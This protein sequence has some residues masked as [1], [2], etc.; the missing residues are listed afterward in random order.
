VSEDRIATKT[1]L[2]RVPGVDEVRVRA[3]LEYGDGLTFDLHALP[4]ASAPLAAVVLVAGYPDPGFERVMGCR[5][6]AMGSTTSWARLI[7]ASGLAAIAYTNE[8]PARDLHALLR[9]VRAHAGELGLDARR[10]GA[11]ASSGNAPLALS[12]AL[13]DAPERLACVALCYGYTLD[14][15][16]ATGV[17]DASRRYGFANACAG[18]GFEA[19]ADDVPLLL[20]RAGG[21]E[22]PG[23]NAALDRFAARAL[24]ANLPLALLN[25]PS[26]AHAFELFDPSPAAGAV[27]EQV[28][29]F[30]RT[31]LYAGDTT[32]NRG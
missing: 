28:L 1:V 21:D 3:G 24:A 12:L 4:G 15:D 20:V 31:R 29:A 23:L 25:H 5:F 30:L 18:R 14:L 27:V 2:H 8:D 16:G 11:W 10:V 9:H 22:L 19:V 32:V 26:G 6:K 7:A 13:R 17:A